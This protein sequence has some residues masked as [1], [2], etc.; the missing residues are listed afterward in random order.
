MLQL[1]LFSPNF[2]LQAPGAPLPHAPASRQGRPRTHLPSCRQAGKSRPK[3]LR[4]HKRPQA[5]RRGGDGAA[6]AVEEGRGF[7]RPLWP[8]ARS[9]PAV[10]AATGSAA[11]FSGQPRRRPTAP[12]KPPKAQ[13][14]EP[15]LCR[16]RPNRTLQVFKHITALPFLALPR[17]FI[18][19]I[20]LCLFLAPGPSR[21]ALCI[22][23]ASS[24]LNLPQG[25]PSH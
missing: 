3:K 10:S 12:P 14:A 2:G 4:L 21:K 23:Q 17:A 11:G 5:P 9:A 15:T 13:A 20:A 25:M 8:A 7:L 1:R 6:A 19:P 18:W 24:F 16:P 22:L